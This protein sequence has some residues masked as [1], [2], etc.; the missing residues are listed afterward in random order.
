MCLMWENSDGWVILSFLSF[1]EMFSLSA[2]TDTDECQDNEVCGQNAKC[3][4][5]PGSYL[6]VCNVGFGLKSGK[7]NFSGNQEQCEGEG[8][9]M[10]LR[11]TGYC[12]TFTSYLI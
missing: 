10:M 5:T 11:N 2:Y 1:S 8:Y 3:I 12:T 4:N 9:G 7:S 6:C